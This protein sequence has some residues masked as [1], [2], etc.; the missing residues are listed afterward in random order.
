[1]AQPTQFMFQHSE[2]V[3]ILIKAQDLHEGYW[4]LS[5]SFGLGAGNIASGEGGEGANPAAIV[6][7]T[8]VG[9]Q[10]VDKANPLAVNAAEVNPSRQES[11]AAAT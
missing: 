1:M 2:L 11:L 5:L 4:M 9:L 10:R 3:A 7:V 8:G 6:A